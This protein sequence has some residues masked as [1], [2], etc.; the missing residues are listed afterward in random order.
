MVQTPSPAITLEEFLKQAE[1]KPASEFVAGRIIQ[2]PMPQGKHSTIQTEF[3]TVVNGA[4]K[5][6]TLARVFSGLRCTFGGRSFVPDVS[7][8]TWKQIPRDAAGEV[9]NSFSVA[10]D[11]AIEIL[12]PDQSQ[13]RVTKNILHCL[14]YGTQMGWL[15]DPEERTIFSYQ[16]KQQPVVLDELAQNLPVPAFAT[17]IKLRVETVFDW[18]RE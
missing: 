1:T 3:A 4:L 7:V 18:L 17:A 12:S 6:G 11:W 5:P 9:A 14:D 15:I 16:P 2:K 10:P 8:F 13:T